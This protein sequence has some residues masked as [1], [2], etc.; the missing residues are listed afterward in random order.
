MTGTGNSVAAS[1][2]GTTPR[3][4]LGRMLLIRR[5]DERV[6]AL[7]KAGVVPGHFSPYVQEAI[8]A[9]GT[10]RLRQNGSAAPRAAH[11]GR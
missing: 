4:L 5:F 9:R 3:D 10:R 6:L 1:F 2:A 8:P 7:Q 11:F